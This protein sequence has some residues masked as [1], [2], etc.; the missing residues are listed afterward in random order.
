MITRVCLANPYYLEGNFS[1]AI[2]L[3]EEARRLQ[4]IGMS[5]HGWLGQ[6]YEADKEYGTALDHHEAY[7][8]AWKGQV[9]ETEAK[10]NRYRSIF[11][12]T[13][14]PQPMWRAM[15][16]DLRQ[17]SSPDHYYDMARLC[18][19]L[20]KTNEVFELLEKGRQAHNGYM[21]FLLIDDC[22]DTLRE[23]PRFDDLLERMGFAKVRPRRK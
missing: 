5:S 16:D 2:E 7:E 4:P 17:N 9:A 20:G 21:E 12:E 13:G 19:R 10:Y 6:G 8:K 1:K 11:A 18:A 23:D 3:W 22:W 14:R 15:L